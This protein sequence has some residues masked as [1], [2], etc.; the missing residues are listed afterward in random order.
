MKKIMVLPFVLILLCYCARTS[1]DFITAAGVVDGEVITVKAAV[2]GEVEKLNISEGAEIAKNDILAEINSEKVINQMQGLDIQEKEI[3][4]NRRKLQRNIQFLQSNLI[5]WKDQVA[6]FERLQEKKSISGDQLEKAQL[7]KEE[8]EASLFDAQQSLESLSNQSEKIQ[9]SKEQF[10]LLLED[11]IITS[12][13]S[14]IVLE[15]FLSEG[16]TVFPGSSV[17]DI[18]DRASLY[19]EVFLEG[20]ELSRLELGQKVEI[21]VDGMEGRVF[22]GTII[23]FGQKAEFSP[24]YIISEKERKSLLYRVKI[25]LEKDLDVFKL[26]MPVTVRIGESGY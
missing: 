12:P 2:T 16:E 18:L 10:R 11:H 5:Y 6:S 26:G 20:Q 22:T 1:P 17:A 25:R 13:V 14:G 4:V 9:N 19:V 23:Y 3:R 21:L 7:K 15:K 8:A 24:K